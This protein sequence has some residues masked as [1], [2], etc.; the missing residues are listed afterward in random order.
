MGMTVLKSDYYQ[1]KDHSLL[2]K[3]KEEKLLKFY[4]I[5]KSEVEKRKIRDILV[6]HNMKFVA[7]VAFSYKSKYTHIPLKDLVGY[8]MLG[9]FK[10][11]ERY[12]YE[13]HKDRKFITYAV[14]W[15]K[16]SINQNMQDLESPVRHPFHVHRQLQIAIN[17]N[18]NNEIVKSKINNLMAGVSLDSSPDGTHSLYNFL[19]D[20]NTYGNPQHNFNEK[21]LNEILKKGIL[22]KLN[23]K[24]AKVIR[25]CFGIDHG[26]Q[27]MY[28]IG[29]TLNVTREAI[30]VTKQSALKKLRSSID[31]KNFYTEEYQSK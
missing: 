25:A 20:N 22:K 15:V 2:S 8:G 27:C 13:Q 4:S 24:E 21:L 11:I 9:L 19:S 26:K 29:T 30:R 31:I 3:E 1:F 18:P 10:A 17:K 28:D 5:S 14:F 23:P 12:E 7:S 6:S 16:Q